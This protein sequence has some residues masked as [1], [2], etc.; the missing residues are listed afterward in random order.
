MVAKRGRLLSS[1]GA[2][3]FVLGGKVAPSV[4]HDAQVPPDTHEPDGEDHGDCRSHGNE[5]ALS[6]VNLVIL[7]FVL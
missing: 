1:E 2:A 4:H 3:L 5:Q 6:L 7:R